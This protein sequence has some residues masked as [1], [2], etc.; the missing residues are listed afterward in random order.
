[1]HS[2]SVPISTGK[3]ISAL[4]RPSTSYRAARAWNTA[5]AGPSKPAP[6]TLAPT[7]TP[8][9]YAPNRT[10][11]PSALRPHCLARDR[12]Y[13]WRPVNARNTLDD[14]GNPTNLGP[15]ELQLVKDMLI[16]TWTESTRQSYASGLLTFHVFCDMKDV[17]EEQRAPACLVL[18]TSFAATLAG[19]YAGATI[20]NYVS[21]IR[22]W[23]ILHGVP[24]NLKSPELNAM[25]KAVEAM[26]PATSKRASRKP[27]TIEF[28]VAI[29]GQ[30]NLDLPLDAAVFACLTTAFYCAARLGEFTVPRLDAF[31]PTIHV[32]PSNMRHERSK[33]GFPITVFFI[34]R[35]KISAHGED[36]YWARQDGPTDPEAAWANHAR[37]ND[38]PA[39]SHLFSHRINKARRPLTKTAIVNRLSKAAKAAGLDPIP[40]QGIR[41]GATLE[42]LTRHLSFEMVK[43]KGRWT[44]NSFQKYL[45]KHAQVM[46]PYM[47]ATP[48]LLDAFSRIALPPVR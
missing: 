38:P 39:D 8:A 14:Q 43:V 10:P 37:V 3:P 40:G 45:R 35:T 25:Y 17:P 18:I 12:L 30:L 31:D 33:E 1:M 41:I 48:Q 16:N 6:T 34:P 46:A 23:H 47:Q 4:K 7:P 29:K 32:K 24:W 27:Y 42:Y 21:G 28:I 22:A 20:S 26:T 2:T 36:V 44:S 11:L 19:V 15:K 13:K 5:I 9:P